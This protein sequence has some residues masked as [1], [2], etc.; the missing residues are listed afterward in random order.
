MN[1]KWNWIKSEIEYLKDNYEF[2]SNDELSIELGRSKKSIYSKS[3]RLGLYK[4]KDFL[5]KYLTKINKSIRRDLNIV[6]V[7]EI[8]KKFK[9]RS[10]FER[11]DG[12][13]YN[14][15]FRNSCIDIVCEHMLPQRFS[16]PQLICKYIFDIIVG[17][18]CEYNTKSII[19]P[20]ELDIYYSKSNLAIEYNGKYWHGEDDNTIKK[21]EMCKHLGIE[22]IV[23]TEDSTD[24]EIDIKNVIIEKLQF[25]NSFLELNITPSFIKDIIIDNNIFNTVLDISDIMKITSSYIGY[26]DFYK[27]N[28]KLARKLT[29]LGMGLSE[30]YTSHMVRN[31]KTEWNIG[32]VHDILVKYDNIHDIRLHNHNCYEYIRNNGLCNLYVEYGYVYKNGKPYKIK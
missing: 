30:K 27:E 17:Y 11:G 24:Y 4:D 16:T 15:C 1:K 3:K 9:T 6:S 20:F 21:V 7:T 22:L 14:W 8:A 2:K 32:K 18:E 19:S 25:I 10:S 13:A 12:G 28:T 5:K 31:K 23:I 26:S 29:R